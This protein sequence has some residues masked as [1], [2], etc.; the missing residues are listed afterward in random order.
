MLYRN[1][2]EGGLNLIYIKTFDL[3]LKSLKITWIRYLLRGNPHV[4]MHKILKSI[5]EECSKSMVPGI[6]KTV[7]IKQIIIFINGEI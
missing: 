6:Q 1:E 7:N 4:V 5:F 2:K 3:S